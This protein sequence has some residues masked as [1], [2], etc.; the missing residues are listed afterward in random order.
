MKKNLILILLLP[1]AFISPGMSQ[2]RITN[3]TDI[4]QI[5]YLAEEGDYIWVCT[6]GGVYKRKKSDGSMVTVFNTGNSGIARNVVKTIYIDFYGNY[7]FGT[8]QGGISRFDGENWITINEIDGKRIWRCETIT[9]DINGNIWFGVNDGQVIKYD[10]EDYELIDL[11]GNWYVGSI[12]SDDLGN[13][14]FGVPG[15]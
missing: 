15:V 8:Y 4:N 3:Y 6:S 2:Y 12:L 7:W 5:N 13:M 9:E 1:F 11:Q 14:W 10:G